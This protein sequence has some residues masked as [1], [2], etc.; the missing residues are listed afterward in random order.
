MTYELAKQL[1]DAGFPISEGSGVSELMKP[2]Y[3]QWLYYPTLSELIE[4]CWKNSHNFIIQTSSTVVGEWAAATC[5]DNGYEDDWQFGKSPEEAVA[6]LWLE[7]NKS[8]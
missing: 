1:K 7:L 6:R 3:E 5:W 8:K 4:V 2:D